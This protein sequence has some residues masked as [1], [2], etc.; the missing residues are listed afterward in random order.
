MIYPEDEFNTIAQS[1]V[2]P[3]GARIL[4]GQLQRI[5]GCR[6]SK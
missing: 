3:N 1:L 6:T 5:V 2:D 4:E